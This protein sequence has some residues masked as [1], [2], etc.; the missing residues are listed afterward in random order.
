MAIVVAPH[1]VAEAIRLGIIDAADAPRFL[2]SPEPA[3]APAPQWRNAAEHLEHIVKS[4][5]SGAAAI[6]SITAHVEEIDSGRMLPAP[7]TNGDP[8]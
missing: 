1:L 3:P 6:D 4:C 2:D 7:P 8:P 5:S